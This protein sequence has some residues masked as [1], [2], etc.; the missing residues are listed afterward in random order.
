MESA[1]LLWYEYGKD[2]DDSILIGVYSSRENA[3]AA[4]ERLRHKPGFV[5]RYEG[6]LIDRYELNKD[7]WTTGFTRDS[8]RPK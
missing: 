5:E 3:E 8:L 1:F 4:M 6:F 2:D 7:H